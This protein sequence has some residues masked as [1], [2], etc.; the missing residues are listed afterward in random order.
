LPSAENERRPQESVNPGRLAARK[1]EM[2]RIHFSKM[3]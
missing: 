3:R 1:I 2:D